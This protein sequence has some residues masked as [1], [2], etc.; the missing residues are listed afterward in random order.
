MSLS[1]RKSSPQKSSSLLSISPC[2][3]GTMLRG[4]YDLSESG[5]GKALVESIQFQLEGNITRY[6]FWIFY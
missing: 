5:A 6:Y 4:A 1:K 3:N 2:A